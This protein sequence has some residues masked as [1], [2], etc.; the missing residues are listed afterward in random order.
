MGRGIPRALRPKISVIVTGQLADKGAAV[1]VHLDEDDAAE[2]VMGAHHIAA[3]DE[4]GSPI[5]R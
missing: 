3:M 1:R 5:I 2:A 4:M